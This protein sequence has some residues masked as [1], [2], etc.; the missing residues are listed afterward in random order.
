[1]K[2]RITVKPLSPA[3][4]GDY[5]AFFDRE[6]FADN[7]DWASCYCMYHHTP[8]DEWES[9]TADENRA[10]VIASID[11]GRLRGYLAYD[12]DAVVG[13]CNANLR[14]NF[15]ALNE[16]PAPSEVGAIVCFVIA[17][18]FRERGIAQRLLTAAC[19]G[20]AR[21]GVGIVE[22]YPRSTAASEAANYHGP[23]AMY[24]TAGFTP[25]REEQ[26]VVI[27]RKQL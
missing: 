26:G 1:L 10:G 11:Q 24:L 21:D 14:R 3:L 23:L 16:D 25:Y 15:T 5:L 6:A 2:G 18:R 22:A 17:K 7:P 19:D 12:G 27:V 9:R 13:W 20:F 8:C 4:R